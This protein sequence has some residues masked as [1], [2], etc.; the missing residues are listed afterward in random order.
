MS[1]ASGALTNA[2]ISNNSWGYSGDNAYDLAAASYDAATR[3]ALPEVTGSQPV[4]FVFAAGN[5]G[6]N[7]HN[8][9]NGD[10]DGGG[11]TPDTI[12]SPGTAKNVI[13]VGALEQLRNIT[14]IVTDLDG[15]G[16]PG[17]AA[18]DGPRL[19]GRVL[20]E[21]GQRRHR[22]RGRLRAFQAGRGRAGIF[23]PLD[24]FNNEWATNVYYNPTNHTD[25]TYTGQSVDQSNIQYYSILV[26][27]NAVSVAV[28]IQTNTSSPSPFPTNLQIYVSQYNY[29]DPT[30]PQGPDNY[31]F[32]TYDDEVMIPPDPDGTGAYLTQIQGTGFNYAVFNT[33]SQTVNYNLSTDVATTND[34]GNYYSVLEGMNDSL[35]GYYRYESGTSMAAADVSGTLALMEDFFHQHAADQSQPGAAEGDAHQRRAA[36]RRRVY[37]LQVNNTI[38]YEGW[39]ADQ[40]AQLAAADDARRISASTC[41]PPFSSRTRAR[42]TRWPPATASRSPSMFP[43]TGRHCP[44]A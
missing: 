20:F 25:Q 39:G 23:C 8:G 1:P 10:N 3:D 41:R 21:P 35:G 2:L 18:A 40:P 22:H 15:N 14:N 12:V 33:N 43:P 4:L 9:A 34:L 11:G 42:P 6:Y 27:Q 13:T 17:M 16:E 30:Q 32:A 5:D 28:E 24:A 29:P 26:P 37:N 19:S 38:N 36:R 31:D 44:C 7:G